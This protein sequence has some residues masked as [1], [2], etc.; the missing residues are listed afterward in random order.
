M[1]LFVF[2]F[3][4]KKKLFE[5]SRRHVVAQWLPWTQPWTKEQ[6]CEMW[7][8]LKKFFSNF[9]AL[10]SISYMKTEVAKL[11]G[12]KYMKV[13]CGTGGAPWRVAGPLFRL[14]TTSSVIPGSSW[15]LGSQRPFFVHLV[16]LHPGNSIHTPFP[17]ACSAAVMHLLHFTVQLDG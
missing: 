5:V 15:H 10:L 1:A 14:F 4:K 9:S 2:M 13:L 17:L 12:S 8:V 6:L 16:Y 11:Y 7:H 3:K